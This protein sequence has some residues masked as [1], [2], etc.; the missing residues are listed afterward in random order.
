MSVGSDEVTLRHIVN[1]ILD[2]EVPLGDDDVVPL[3]DD[4]DDTR[5]DV[6]MERLSEELAAATAASEEVSKTMPDADG[7][8]GIESVGM[9]SKENSGANGSSYKQMRSKHALKK[10]WAMRRKQR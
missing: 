1:C 10:Y 6:L 2:N 7:E 8:G 3:E 5:R 9:E 4:S